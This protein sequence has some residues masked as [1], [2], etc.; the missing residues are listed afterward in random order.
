LTESL[1]MYPASSVCGWYFANPESKY[2]GI[3]KIEKDQV[4]DYA[5]RKN[6]QLED[7]ERWLRP[8]L[9]YDA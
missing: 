7:L 4:I 2:F 6:M 9:E 5:Q 8:V 1:A 3:G